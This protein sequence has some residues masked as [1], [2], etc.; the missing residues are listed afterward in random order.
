MDTAPLPP[1]LTSSLVLPPTGPGA[2]VRAGGTPLHR[3]APRQHQDRDPARGPPVRQHGGPGA[4]P[5]KS[6]LRV[7]LFAI[8][9][10]I[11]STGTGFG[12]V[13][14]A[15]GHSVFLFGSMSQHMGDP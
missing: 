8:T 2:R 3:D 14:L 1:P 12:F 7:L 11:S 15:I 5:E 10:F 9:L 4:F 13:S 6:A